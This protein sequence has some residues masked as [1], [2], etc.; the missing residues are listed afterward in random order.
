MKQKSSFQPGD[1]VRIKHTMIQYSGHYG[2]LGTL[3]EHVQTYRN[4]SPM[5][6]QNAFSTSWKVLL[7]NNQI[8]WFDVSDIEIACQENE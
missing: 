7:E 3:I 4:V 5:T 8:A 2:K 1:I 6:E